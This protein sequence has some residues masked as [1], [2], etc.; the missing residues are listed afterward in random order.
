MY[1]GVFQQPVIFGQ[2]RSP[3][4]PT[5]TDD[6]GED[7]PASKKICLP[8]QTDLIRIDSNPELE[9]TYDVHYD[10]EIQI[11]STNLLTLLSSVK[12]VLLLYV[13]A[14]KTNTLQ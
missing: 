5:T 11:G 10:E 9:K 6:D 3:Y 4:T 12:L 7:D 1:E 2:G 14:M 8:L 13:K